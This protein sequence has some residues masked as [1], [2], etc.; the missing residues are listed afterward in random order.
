MKTTISKRAHKLV[1]DAV[2]SGLLPNLKAVYIQCYDCFKKAMYWDHRDY[3]LPLDVHPVCG[4]CN[5]KRGP[6]D[7]K[8][9]EDRG[10][11]LATIVM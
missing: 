8:F 11:K 3:R 6:A 7:G 2:H 4:H 10:D 1:N 5:A 9:P